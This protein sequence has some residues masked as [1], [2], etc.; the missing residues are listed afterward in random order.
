MRLCVCVCVC[1]CVIECV[2]ASVCAD[3]VSVRERKWGALVHVYY[4]SILT[5]NS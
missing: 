2:C 3:V 1:V 5:P 4:N